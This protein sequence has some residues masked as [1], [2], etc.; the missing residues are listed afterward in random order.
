MTKQEALY[1]LCLRIGDTSLIH[2]HRLSEWC[3]HGPILEEDIALTN[4]ALDLVGQSRTLLQYAS[5]I[6]G[7]G[8]TEDDIAYLRPEREFLNALIAER[9]N[10]DYAATTE[11]Q[12]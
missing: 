4:I 12:R 3:G 10:G 6:E 8:R 9:P 7:K 11:K 2:G 5:Q 1:N